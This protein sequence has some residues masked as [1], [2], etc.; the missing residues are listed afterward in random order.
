MQMLWIRLPAIVYSCG[1]K[2]WASSQ[3]FGQ[4][5]TSA[6]HKNMCAARCTHENSIIHHM[7][8]M[9]FDLMTFRVEVFH[10]DYRAVMQ[11]LM[12]IPFETKEWTWVIYINNVLS[13]KTILFHILDFWCQLEQIRFVKTLSK[14]RMFVSFMK[15]SACWL[16]HRL[17]RFNKICWEKRPAKDRPNLRTSFWRRDLKNTQPHLKVGLGI[18]R[19]NADSQWNQVYN[20]FHRNFCCGNETI[21]Q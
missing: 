14:R 12:Q 8:P 20:V 6:S 4:N 18:S 9:G 16:L 19:T 17:I 13:I 2:L 11:I 3:F 21:R 10:D 15:I 5:K 1:R 7:Y